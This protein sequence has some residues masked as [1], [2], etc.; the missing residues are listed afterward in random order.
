[1]ISPIV[2]LIYYDSIHRGRQLF[3]I[4]QYTVLF[5]KSR[6]TPAV[7]AQTHHPSAFQYFQTLLNCSH[8]GLRL[9]RN[10]VISAG[11]I[12]EVKTYGVRCLFFY[13]TREQFTCAMSKLG[14]S[15]AK[16]EKLDYVFNVSEK[17]KMFVDFHIEQKPE[18]TLPNIPYM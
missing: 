3:N 9:C 6:I 2:I 7:D 8:A 4:L 1:M 10:A 11:K 12:P 18:N 17:S 5:F 14:F 13:V 15:V 16:N